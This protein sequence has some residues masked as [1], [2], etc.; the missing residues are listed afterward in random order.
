MLV[1]SGQLL[2]AARQRAFCAN[3]RPRLNPGR[4]PL[5]AVIAVATEGRAAQPSAPLIPCIYNFSL[6]PITTLV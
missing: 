5:N 6:I 4:R 2:W 3:S 1:L